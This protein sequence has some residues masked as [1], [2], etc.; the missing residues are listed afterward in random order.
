MQKEWV[1][2]TEYGLK[3]GILIWDLSTANDTIDTIVQKNENMTN[4]FNYGVHFQF[5]L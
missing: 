5:S 4:Q 2:N 3:T 1:Q